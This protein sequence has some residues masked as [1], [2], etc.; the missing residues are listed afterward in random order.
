[1]EEEGGMEWKGYNPR[2]GDGVSLSPFSSLL[3]LDEK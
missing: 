1:M 2:E 3:K